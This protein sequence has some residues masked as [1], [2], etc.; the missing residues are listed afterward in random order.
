MTVRGYMNNDNYYKYSSY[1]WLPFPDSVQDR[2]CPLDTTS[3]IAL[4]VIQPM[5]QVP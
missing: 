1:F 4:T 5:Y 2:L 3:E